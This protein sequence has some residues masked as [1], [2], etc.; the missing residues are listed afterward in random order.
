MKQNGFR[1]AVAAA[2]AIGAIAVGQLHAH[3]MMTRSAAPAGSD[4]FSPLFASRLEVGLQNMNK[5]AD[6]VYVAGLMTDQDPVGTPL[7]ANPASLCLGSGCLGSACLG[8][9]CILSGCF[10]SACASSKCVGSGCVVSIC[11]GSACLTSVCVGSGCVSSGCVGSACVGS[12][13]IGSACIRCLGPEPGE[14]M[15]VGE[16]G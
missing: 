7:S 3:S 10:G 13:C 16:P 1:T 11:G 2:V 5:P 14:T 15:E 4:G 6:R 8:S 12:G 9:A